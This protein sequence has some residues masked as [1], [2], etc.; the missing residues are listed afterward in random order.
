MTATIQRQPLSAG[1]KRLATNRMPREVGGDER[2]QRGP[3]EP[4]AMPLMGPANH[5]PGLPIMGAPAY[6]PHPVMGG[7]DA[8]AHV[9]VMGAGDRGAPTGLFGDSGPGFVDMLFTPRWR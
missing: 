3:A 1:T 6:S 7:P 4:I 8:A 9:S 5:A 2:S